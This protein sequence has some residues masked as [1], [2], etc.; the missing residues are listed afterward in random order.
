MLYTISPSVANA[1]NVAA[2]LVS[3]TSS[4]TIGTVRTDRGTVVRAMS[5]SETVAMA[6]QYQRFLVNV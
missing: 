6:N 5:P 3:N 4:E 1:M 2:M